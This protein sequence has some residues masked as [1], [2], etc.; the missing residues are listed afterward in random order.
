MTI[1]LRYKFEIIFS[2]IG[3]FAGYA[4]WYYIGCASG[5]CAITA[6]WYTSSIYGVI[7]G[8]L[9]GQILSEYLKKRIKRKEE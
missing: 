6:R 5:T 4:Y 7:I 1:I 9:G 3:F 2:V 8:F